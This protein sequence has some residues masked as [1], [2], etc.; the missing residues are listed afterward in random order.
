MQETWVQSVGQEGD[1][2]EE[3]A[4]YSSILVWRIPW[5]EEPGEL[6]S[7]RLQRGGHN[8]W[9]IYVKN[10]LSHYDL[11]HDIEYNSLC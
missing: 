8:I 2:E 3:M 9:N 7:L 11:P 4:V 5:T 10:I 1:V 6:Q